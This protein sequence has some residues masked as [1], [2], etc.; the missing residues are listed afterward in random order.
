MAVP[1]TLILNRSISMT[2][3]IHKHHII[4]RH[5]GGTDDPSNLVELTVEEHAEAHELLYEKYGHDQDRVAALM[6]RGQIS[7][8]DAFIEMVSRPKSEEWKKSMSERNIGEGNPMWGNT[9]K[10]SEEAKKKISVKMKG[11]PK[12]YKVTN[13]VMFGKD[14]PK[15]RTVIADGVRYESL[16]SACD[17]YG[18]KN[19]NAGRYRINSD[20]WDW[21]Y[22]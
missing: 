16:R 17:A 21:H 13:P 22:A 15:S 5:M 3:Y 8:Y 1:T 6:L 10:H 4:P 2:I 9:F 19:H 7:N 20:K 14:N 18:L 12:N 11:V